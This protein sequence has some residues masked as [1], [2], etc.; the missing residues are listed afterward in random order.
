V[1]SRCSPNADPCSY[2]SASSIALRSV[3]RPIS[4]STRLEVH[5]EVPHL[6]KRVSKTTSPSFGVLLMCHDLHERIEGLE[7]TWR[8][9]LACKTITD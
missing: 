2:T 3:G 7:L 6:S 1:T 8:L 4:S 5:I 9:A